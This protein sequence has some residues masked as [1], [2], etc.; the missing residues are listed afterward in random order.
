MKLKDFCYKA[1]V[2]DLV[3][4]D[5][6]AL[7]ELFDRDFKQLHENEMQA[8]FNFLENV[9]VYEIMCHQCRNLISTPNELIRYFGSNI[10]RNC[11]K[12]YYPKQREKIEENERIYFDRVHSLIC[13]GL[14]DRL[15]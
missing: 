6:K 13:L 15:F 9:K 10:H 5:S 7:M 8:H 11:F 12:D 2:I 1:R 3:V 4:I 14:R